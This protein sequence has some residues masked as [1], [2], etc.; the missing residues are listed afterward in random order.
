MATLAQR[1]SANRMA[2]DYVSGLY[3]PAIARFRARKQD[4]GRVARELAAWRR[5]LESHWS[6]L[7]F[8]AIELRRE[9][10]LVEANVRVAL[11]EVDASSIAVEL[12]AD[13]EAP[14]ALA[15]LGATGEWM[16]YAG[17]FRSARPTQ[18]FSVRIVPRHREA[19][20]PSE[21]PLIQWSR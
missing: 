20:I 9:G 5:R 3:R 15:P 13:G 12:F 2:S 6:Q 21:A 1:F 11:G 4:G 10:D 7:R 16:Q 18:D 14:F 19:W 17:A 8:G